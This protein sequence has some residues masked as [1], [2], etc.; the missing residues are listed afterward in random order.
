[1]TNKKQKRFFRVVEVAKFRS[2]TLTYIVK[3]LGRIKKKVEKLQIEMTSN[4]HRKLMRV[5]NVIN[6]RLKLR[7]AWRRMEQR[8]G[9]RSWPDR[10]PI[11][12][13]PE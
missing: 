8:I 11:N 3:K 4:D 12:R 7:A 9:S 1:M 5:T 13:R 6:E 10:V 2:G